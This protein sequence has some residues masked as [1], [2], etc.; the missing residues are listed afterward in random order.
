VTGGVFTSTIICIMTL[1]IFWRHRGNIQ[2]LWA[3]TE[4]RIGDKS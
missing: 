2:R 4:G 3:G 1:F